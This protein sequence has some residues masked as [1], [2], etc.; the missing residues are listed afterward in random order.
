MLLIVVM[1]LAPVRSTAAS[2]RSRRSCRLL[3]AAVY[4]GA[5][6]LAFNGGKVLPIIYPMLGLG[7]SGVGSLGLAYITTAFDRQRTKDTFSRFVPPSVV[8]EVLER[9]DGVRLGGEKTE[10]TV[11]FSDIR[12]F[13]TFSE[14][15]S[16]EQVIEILNRYLRR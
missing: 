9:A 3:V 10:A 15:R 12:G 11:L 1:A 14:S 16:P 5:S 8:G 13:T 4:L 2:G 7:A 6:L